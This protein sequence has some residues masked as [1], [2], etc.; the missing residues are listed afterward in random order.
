MKIQN[1]SLANYKKNMKIQNISLANYK[2]KYENT[3][4]FVLNSLPLLL[5]LPFK[6]SKINRIL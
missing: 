3:K 6:I 1:I 4:Y 5:Y 2:K